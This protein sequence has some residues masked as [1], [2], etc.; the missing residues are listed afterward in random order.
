MNL[1][2]PIARTEKLNQSVVEPISN[3][4]MKNIRFMRDTASTIKVL[5]DI[6][7]MSYFKANFKL[8][9]K[10]KIKTCFKFFF[11]WHRTLLQKLYSYGI[12]G[13]ILAWLES[14]LSDRRQRVGIS[15]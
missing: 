7:L 12:N 3:Q 14:F 9:S 4:A 6:N 11:D 5:S 13:E 1:T 2:I 10:K 15:G 8:V